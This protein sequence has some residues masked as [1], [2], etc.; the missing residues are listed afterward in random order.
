MALTRMFPKSA[1]RCFH[2]T[3][4]GSV[5]RHFSDTEVRNGSYKLVIV[6]GGTGGCA[7]AARFCRELGRGHVAVIEPSQVRFQIDLIFSYCIFLDLPPVAH[8]TVHS[9]VGPA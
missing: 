4:V 1:G 6:G 7:T 2:Q 9:A 5:V 3:D 8:C